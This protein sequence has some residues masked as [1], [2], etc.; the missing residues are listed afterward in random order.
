MLVELAEETV[1][2]VHT[3]VQVAPLGVYV[4]HAARQVGHVRHASARVLEH[5]VAGLEHALDVRLASVQVRLELLD[6]Q[7]INFAI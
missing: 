3:L 7:N 1:L 2:G 4:D 6:E 5:L